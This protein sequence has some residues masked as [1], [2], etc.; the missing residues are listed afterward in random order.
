MKLRRMKSNI[1]RS[2]LSHIGC[3]THV[4]DV[5]VTPNPSTHAFCCHVVNYLHEDEGGI[6]KY[7]NYLQSKL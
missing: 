1:Q 7:E 2:Q 3:E 4:F 5:S 6:Q